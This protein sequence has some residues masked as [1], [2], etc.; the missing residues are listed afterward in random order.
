MPLHRLT[1]VAELPKGEGRTFV[2]GG[3]RLAVFRTRGD[4]LFATQAECPHKQG[5][6]ADGLLGGAL[7]IC[8]LHEWRFDLRTGECLNQKCSITVYPTQS[9][10]AGEIEVLLPD[11]RLADP[12]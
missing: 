8:P 1:T 5:P 10:A 4:Q 12:R 2:V 3:L 9:N 6:L 11:T 7:L